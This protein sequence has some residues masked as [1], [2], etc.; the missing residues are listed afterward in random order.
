[1]PLL[2]PDE[3]WYRLEQDETRRWQWTAPQSDMLLV[4]PLVAPLTV[5]VQ[6][7]VK[8]PVDNQ[9]VRIWLDD[10]RLW[11]GQVGRAPWERSFWLRLAP[12][13]VRRLT[14]QTEPVQEQ[15]TSERE[16]GLVFTAISA[17]SATSVDPASACPPAPA[18][19]PGIVP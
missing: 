12:Q 10:M 1:M 13:Q 8:A 6:F 2:L 18:L 3:G 14:F 4:N 7:E 19:P 5:Q 9:T 11:Q 15:G 17:E 16:L